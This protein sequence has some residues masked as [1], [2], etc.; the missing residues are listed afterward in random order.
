MTF[1]IDLIN[2][3]LEDSERI[4]EI[5]EIQIELPEETEEK[6]KKSLSTTRNQTQ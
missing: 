4:Q 1:L 2:W 6:I 5:K 3:I